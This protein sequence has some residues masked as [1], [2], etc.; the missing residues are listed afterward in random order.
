M[1][2]RPGVP[3]VGRVQRDQ[4]KWWV[5]ICSVDQKPVQQ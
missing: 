2:R 1:R 3:A 5:S 4:R